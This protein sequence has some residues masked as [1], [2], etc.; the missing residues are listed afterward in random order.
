[1]SCS[2]TIRIP[3]TK[4]HVSGDKL[5]AHKYTRSQIY[6]VGSNQHSQCTLHHVNMMV[7]R[8]RWCHNILPILSFSGVSVS[9]HFFTS[10]RLGLCPSH[11]QLPFM[12]FPPSQEEAR[13]PS[14]QE[15]KNVLSA[16]LLTRKSIQELKT[17]SYFDSS[18]NH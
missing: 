5:P 10:M 17:P 16:K 15:E 12:S 18:T 8:N 11:V 13:N 14:V 1:M 4:S 9:P 3:A 6:L 7:C 2:K